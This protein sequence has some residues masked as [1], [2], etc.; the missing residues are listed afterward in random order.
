M[1]VGGVEIN[2]VPRVTHHVNTTEVLVV[3]LF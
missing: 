1:G 3:N 2:G